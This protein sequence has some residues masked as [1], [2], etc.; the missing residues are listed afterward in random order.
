MPPHVVSVAAPGPLADPISVLGLAAA[1]SW[2]AWRFGPTLL[3][4][5]GWCSWWVAWACGSQGGYAYAA[6]FLLLG[7]LAWSAGTVWYAKRRGRWPSALSG[8]LL[9]RIL[10]KRSPLAAA[11]HAP[12]A[13]V[14]RPH[15]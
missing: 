10:G 1:F 13:I 8:R 6:A 2:I 3:R 15:R 12:L 9:T 11:E 4:L 14:P 5:A 7:A